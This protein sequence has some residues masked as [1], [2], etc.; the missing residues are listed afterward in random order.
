MSWGPHG[1][2]PGSVGGRGNSGR[3]GW[4][5]EN[6][7]ESLYCGFCRKEQVGLGEQA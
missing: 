1:E 7:G 3:V 6:V 5:G 2:A 4:G